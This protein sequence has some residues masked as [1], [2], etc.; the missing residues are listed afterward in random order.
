MSYRAGMTVYEKCYSH[1]RVIRNNI[2]HANKAYRPDTPE[3]LK[4]L[5]DWAEC[6]IA[7]VYETESTFATCAQEIK[8]TMKIE[9]F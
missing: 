7:T 3:R 1:L 2:I 6:F 5:L 4:E 8:A 9:S